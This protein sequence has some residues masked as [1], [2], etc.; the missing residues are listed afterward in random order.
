MYQINA[1]WD[2][3]QL[4]FHQADCIHSSWPH[5]DHFFYY[6]YCISFIYWEKTQSNTSKGWQCNLSRGGVGTSTPDVHH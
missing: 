6:N 2:C 1:F 3:A 4:S 5:A